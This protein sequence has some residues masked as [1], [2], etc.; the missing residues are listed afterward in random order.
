MG[1]AAVVSGRMTDR[2]IS[3]PMKPTTIRF[4]DELR[5]QMDD[6]VETGGYADRS[7]LI[8]QAVRRQLQ[9]EAT[10]ATRAEAADE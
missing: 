9:R 4:T 1:P 3:S 10:L 7:A 2:D 6:A 8:R 5:E